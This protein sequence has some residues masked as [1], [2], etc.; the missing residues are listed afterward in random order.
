MITGLLPADALAWRAQQDD[1]LL[2]CLYLDELV[3]DFFPCVLSA[4][5][6]V[7]TVRSR[8]RPRQG[9]H[10]PAFLELPLAVCPP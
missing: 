4:K 10:R 7:L 5:P 3:S 2:R 9:T 6:V 8:R 1:P